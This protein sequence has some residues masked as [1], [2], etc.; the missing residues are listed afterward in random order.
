VLE[1]NGTATPDVPT[2][3]QATQ[4]LSWGDSLLLV[5][6]R[7]NIRR[8]INVFFG[9]APGAESQ[10]P[11]LAFPR[12]GPTGRIEL[13]RRGNEVQVATSGVRK[14]TLLLSPSQ[15]NLNESIRVSVNGHVVFEGRVPRRTETL[16]EWALRDRDRTML[17]LAELTIDLAGPD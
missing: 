10:A 13:E 14:F 9:A 5:V 2:L 6:D 7:D 15:F 12:A 16:V 4:G 17:Y 1:A 3:L 8:R 11:V